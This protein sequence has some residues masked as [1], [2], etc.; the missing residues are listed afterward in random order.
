MAAVNSYLEGIDCLTP[1]ACMAAGTGGTILGSPGGPHPSAPIAALPAL[2]D[3][4]Y[5]GYTTA[6]YIQS[7]APAIAHVSIRY[8]D[9]DGN[10]IG[11]G[12]SGAI[13]PGGT[14]TIRQD[15]GNS[16]VPGFAGSGVI[17]S[18]QMIVAFVNEFAPGGTAD[19]TSYTAKDIHSRVFGTL[20]VPAVANVAY[21]GYTTGI[22]LINLSRSVATITV[23][24]RDGA[25]AV[26]KTQTLTDVPAEAYRA[27]Y[28]GDLALG[29]PQGFAGTATIQSSADRI[30]AVVNEVGPGGQFSSY[31]AATEAGYLL[32][33][34]AALNNAY[35]GYVT[36]M[37]IQNTSDFAANF[38]I[39]YYDSTGAVTSRNFSIAADGYLGVYQGTDIPTPGAYTAVVSSPSA[40]LVIIVN[41]VAPP[42]GPARQ[43]T[44]YNTFIQGFPT[45]HL[46][47]VESAGSD[48]WSTGEGIMNTGPAATTVTVTYY[49]TLSGAEVGT[50]QSQVL[51]SRAF[52]GVYQPTGGLPDG[53]RANAIV[54]TSADGQIAV[55]CNES[56]A[57]S[58]MSYTG[59]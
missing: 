9:T 53:A 10:A 31:D 16:F 14:A 6:V 13:A 44:A 55:I 37:G 24:Y 52:M 18:D 56:N 23:T 3:A 26:I 59:Q 22:G 5:G 19:A 49:D 54:T 43:S 20:Y 50:P 29:L 30:A 35:G 4:A 7:V 45:L 15:G 48:G 2:A 32:F 41:E 39:Y 12:D 57:H 38:G 11:A 33:A 42:N 36:G 46:P 8:F 51:E 17:W 34:P 47:L 27:L 28:S 40:A 21:G 1:T 25:G 58:F